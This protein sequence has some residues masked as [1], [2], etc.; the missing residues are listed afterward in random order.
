MC[1]LIALVWNYNNITCFL[2]VD[3]LCQARNAYMMF[4]LILT[5]IV[6]QQEDRI[7][8]VPIVNYTDAKGVAD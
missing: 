5:I 7:G 4:N 8:K 3:L 6:L 2:G 1:A